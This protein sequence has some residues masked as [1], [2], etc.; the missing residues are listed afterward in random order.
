MIGVQVRADWLGFSV[1][2]LTYGIVTLGRG[3]QHL[4]RIVC[5]VAVALGLL[6][7]GYIV[8]FQLPSPV[9]RGGTISSREIIGRALAPLNSDI[10]RQYSHNA[11][12]YAGTFSWRTEWW[13]AIWTSVLAE[14][15]RAVIGYGYGYPLYS[16]TNYVPNDVR[17]PHNVFIYA[18]GYGGWVGVAIFFLLQFSLLRLLLQAY[19]ITGQPFGIMYWATALSGAFFS[20]FFE[21][22]FGAIPFY[23]LVGLAAAPALIQANVMPTPD[24]TSLR[25]AAMGGRKA[26]TIAGQDARRSASHGND[27]RGGLPRD[28]TMAQK[29]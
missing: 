22:P 20:N 8:D 2:L 1:G 6:V 21:T 12:S 27:T 7:V 26:T 18:L 11:D 19:R 29:R 10:A 14:P 3:F 25:V 15:V 28:L 4:Q 23:L 13:H 17:T 5:A 24:Q 16:L 9:G